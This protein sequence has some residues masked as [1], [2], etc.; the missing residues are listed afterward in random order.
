MCAVLPW[1]LEGQWPRKPFGFLSRRTF[2]DGDNPIQR[3]CDLQVLYR[4]CWFASP[5]DVSREVNDGR[6]PVD[7]KI[8]RGARDKT[9]VEFKL[10]KNTKLS[11]NLRNQTPVYEK[12]S[13]APRC[14]KV[15]LALSEAELARV[16]RIVSDLGLRRSPDVVVID[17]D[18]DNKPSG[19]IA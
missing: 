6:G 15:I 1:S 13:D 3:E 10:A 16:Y 18:K 7:F 17:A 2:W 8:S 11:Q 4:L 9:L 5:S 12:A 14:I 19:S